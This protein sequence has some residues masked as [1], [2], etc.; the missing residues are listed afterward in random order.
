MNSTLDD[1]GIESKELRKKGRITEDGAVLLGRNFACDG[2]ADRPV[3]VLTHVHSDHLYGLNESLEKCEEVVMTPQTK[4]MLEI[5]Y[6]D[7]FEDLD[8]VKTLEYGKK[9]RYGDEELTLHKAHHI[10]GASQTRVKTSTGEKLL[11]T[12]DFKKPGTP[13]RDC[14]LL[15]TE[16]TYGKPYQM[17]P[18][19]TE[20][21]DI[22]T[23]FV[24]ERLENGPVNI[25]G[26]HGKLQESLQILREKGVENPAFMPDRIYETAQVYEENGRNV[27][28]YHPLE[29]LNDGHDSEDNPIRLFHANSNRDFGVESVQV[30][31]SG[32]EFVEPV[33]SLGDNYSIALSDHSDFQQLIEHVKQCE[34]D[35]VITDNHRSNGAGILAEEIT[36]RTQIP[37]KK[38]PR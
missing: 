34:P 18:F 22:F 25:L 27:G 20:I 35:Y 14:D 3:R 31:L 13:P 17:R 29:S 28:E 12:G 1:Y 6:D 15:L 30:K 38:M 37:A 5:L 19:R 16:A 23:R 26:Y 2:H 4:S 32:W 9:F 33:K 10:L 11:F 7:R 36:K 21:K 24:Q 8:K